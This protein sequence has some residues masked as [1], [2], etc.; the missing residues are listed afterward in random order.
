VK[1]E[2][3][4]DD[5]TTP[6]NRQIPVEQPKPLQEQKI[7]YRGM[8]GRLIPNNKTKPTNSPKPSVICPNT[9]QKLHKP[10]PESIIMPSVVPSLLD[11]FSDEEALKIVEPP[12]VP[13][14]TEPQPRKTTVI[15]QGQAQHPLQVPPKVAHHHPKYR[16][17]SNPEV[18]TSTQTPEGRRPSIGDGSKSSTVITPNTPKSRLAIENHVPSRKLSQISQD[19]S[20]TIKLPKPRNTPAIPPATQS[21][22]S[23]TSVIHSTSN[24]PKQHAKVKQTQP[25]QNLP[26]LQ[27]PKLSM[28]KRTPQGPSAPQPVT[29]IQAQSNIR[30]PMIIQRQQTVP[31]VVKMPP[32]QVQTKIVSPT[33]SGILS[34]PPQQQPR[35]VQAPRV[36][37]QVH[38]TNPSQAHLQVPA[39]PSQQQIVRIAQQPRS[40]QPSAVF[41]ISNPITST[42]G[43]YAT[44]A[45]SVVAGRPQQVIQVPVHGNQPPNTYQHVVVTPSPKQIATKPGQGM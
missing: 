44:Y 25:V 14:K 37:H 28:A 22:Y 1:P 11:Q 45:P 27:K 20:E 42:G 26:G 10:E 2:Q 3:S 31:T 33:S 40:Q 35:M 9:Q 15:T 30:G 5:A 18:P 4:V 39:S 19:G 7:P 13:E 43:S 17:V 21:T 36:I 12:E 23:A 29:T 8:K 32:A 24:P 34:P 41:Q 38:N 6:N 16:R